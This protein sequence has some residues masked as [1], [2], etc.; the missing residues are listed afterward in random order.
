MTAQQNQ[1]FD[2]LT[3]MRQKWVDANRANGF[4]NGLKNLLTDLYPDNAHFIYELLQNAEDARA[5]TVRF[6]LTDACVEFEHDGK[7]LFSEKRD[8]QAPFPPPR[9]LRLHRG[10]GRLVLSTY[11]PT[12]VR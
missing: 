7:R 11:V 9:A 10:P 6:T 1:W 3:A 8:L 12:G 4:E 5:T 2:A